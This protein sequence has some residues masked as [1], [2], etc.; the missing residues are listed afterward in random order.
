[1]TETYEGWA[2]VEPPDHEAHRQGKAP[3]VKISKKIARTVFPTVVPA[4][5]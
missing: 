3:R 4:S 1:M 2:P 5:A